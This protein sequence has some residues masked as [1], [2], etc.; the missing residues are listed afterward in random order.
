M[1]LKKKI[2]K[3]FKK[4]I[5][6]LFI[7]LYG[8]INIQ[9]KGNN[10]KIKIKKISQISVNNKRYKTNNYL[11][12]IKDARIYTDLNEHVSIIKD[13]YIIPE[14]SFQQIKGNLKNIKYN[15]IL[16][17][18]TPYFIKEFKGVIFSLV[19]GGSSNNYFHFLF[20]I[21]TRLKILQQS[22][23]L[24]K[25]DYFYINQKINWQI[26]FFKFFFKIPHKKLLFAENLRHIKASKVL[27]VKHPWYHK[28]YFQQQIKNI[29]NWLILYLR[30]NFLGYK[31][32]FKNNKKIFINR[33]DSVFSH[34]KIINNKEVFDLLKKK[35]FS[36][37]KV[38]NLSFFQQIYLFNS[39]K[40]IVGPHGAAFTNIIFCKKN[41]KIIELI[42]KKHESV[43]CRKIS[44]LLKLKYR[45]IEIKKN[46][47]N[48]NLG[49]MY[50]DKS[51]MRRIIN[52]I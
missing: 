29:P 30:N 3:K 49:D 40:I 7:L 35:G 21:V 32:K 11:Y 43:K 12:E 15:K 25:I 8:K 1:N 47:N 16:K 20:D 44:K 14:I 28:G 48:L 17:E 18:G 24:N 41:T 6:K 34:C 33:S 26:K 27:V 10:L 38:S 9:K 4:I 50:I 42:P 51:V 37:Y 13:N 5:Q 39:A 22:Y 36:S 2:E 23:D 45:R 19:Q 52:S 31:K 46:L